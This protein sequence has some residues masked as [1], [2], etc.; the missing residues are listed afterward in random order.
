MQTWAF[1]QVMKE[2][3]N[4]SYAQVSLGQSSRYTDPNVCVDL[5]DD[6][7]AAGREQVHSDPAAELWHGHRPR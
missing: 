3:A 7:E 1:L 6:K 2:D 5:A 4:P